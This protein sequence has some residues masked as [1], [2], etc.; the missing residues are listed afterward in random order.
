MEI[1]K[2]DYKNMHYAVDAKALFFYPNTNPQI[3]SEFFKDEKNIMIV[4]IEHNQVIGMLYGYTLERFDRPT[5][6]LF[7]YSIDVVEEHRNKGIGKQLVA[8]FL[9]PLKSDEY[10]SAFVLTQEKNFLAKQLYATMG[11]KKQPSNAGADVLFKW[12][13]YSQQNER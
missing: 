6:Q 1:L 7:L 10:E 12:D 4:A 2:I 5:K 3:N 13:K 11:A 8:A 9:E